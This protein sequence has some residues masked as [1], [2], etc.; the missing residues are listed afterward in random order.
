[1]PGTLSIQLKSSGAVPLL[2]AEC[3][4]DGRVRLARWHD[5][6]APALPIE[7]TF[8]SD[9]LPAIADRARAGNQR[10]QGMV[11]VEGTRLAP[12]RATSPAPSS[13]PR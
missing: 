11:P 5:P 10:Y 4:R 2:Y 6:V 13:C 7:C 12:S 3:T 9:A 8:G 1:M